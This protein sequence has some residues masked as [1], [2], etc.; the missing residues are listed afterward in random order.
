MRGSLQGHLSHHPINILSTMATFSLWH[1]CLSKHVVNPLSPFLDQK[2]HNHYQILGFKSILIKYYFFR[3]RPLMSVGGWRLVVEWPTWKGVLISTTSSF[4]EVSYWAPN[5]ST[6]PTPE[7][8]WPQPHW[9]FPTQT[10]SYAIYAH[11]RINEHVLPQ[12]VKK[13]SH[14]PIKVLF[15]HPLKAGWLEEKTGFGEL[16]GEYGIVVCGVIPLWVR[17]CWI[18]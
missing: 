12:T 4:C 15:K 11:I 18:V 2:E 9:I 5:D 16:R 1:C 3:G 6:S 8:D 17:R 10:H 7:K 13:Y 14:H